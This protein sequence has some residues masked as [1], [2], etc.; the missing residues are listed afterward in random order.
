MRS[1][2]EVVDDCLGLVRTLSRRN[3]DGRGLDPTTKTTGAIK[4]GPNTI[5][6][7]VRT[8]TPNGQYRIVLDYYAL[9]SIV[10]WVRSTVLLDSQ[11]VPSLR[12]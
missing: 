5:G 4:A 10:V 1:V 11:P 12:S 3:P 6:Q 7:P 9:A 8:N 2:R